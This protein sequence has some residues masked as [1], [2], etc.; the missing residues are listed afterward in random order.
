MDV[1]GHS[2]IRV[3]MDT[4]S[5]VLDDLKRAAAKKMDALL[6]GKV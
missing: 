6:D 2:S 1:L 4:Y 5:H 3:T